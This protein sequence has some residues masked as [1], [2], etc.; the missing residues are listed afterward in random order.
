MKMKKDPSFILASM[1]LRMLLPICEHIFYRIIGPL[2]THLYDLFSL[3][4]CMSDILIIISSISYYKRISDSRERSG[5]LML[6]ITYF[7]DILLSYLS[8]VAL[9][10]KHPELYTLLVTLFMVIVPVG[11]LFSLRMSKQIYQRPLILQGRKLIG[12]YA[13]GIIIVTLLGVVEEYIYGFHTDEEIYLYW[14]TILN[15]KFLLNILLL[16]IST[17]LGLYGI[18]LIN[19]S[20]KEMS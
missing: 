12:A 10:S 9:D 14:T 18:Y 13:I 17:L 16:V 1:C 6:S 4:Y 7:I 20:I 19:K 8:N 11:L 3:S 5:L 15:V 2:P